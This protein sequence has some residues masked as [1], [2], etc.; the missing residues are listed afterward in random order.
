M[1]AGKRILIAVDGSSYSLQAIKY[2]A[3][4]CS[5][6]PVEVG[7]LHVLPMASEELLWQINV[8]ENF[9]SKIKSNTSASTTNASV[10]LRNS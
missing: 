6:A 8:D 9:K 4:L 1:E 3:T 5:G 10:R 2:V 7:L